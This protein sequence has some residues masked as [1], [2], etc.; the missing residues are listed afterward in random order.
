MT[1]EDKKPLE[2]KPRSTNCCSSW[3]SLLLY[4]FIE[5]VIELTV[6]IVEECHCFQLNAK[7]YPLFFTH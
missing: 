6:V 5:R 7:F 2:V 3:R 1:F 4:L